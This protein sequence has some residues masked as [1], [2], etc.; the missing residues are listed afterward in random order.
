MSDAPTPDETR[1]FDRKFIGVSAAA[2][3]T[4]MLAGALAR[5]ASAAPAA[6][7]EEAT[8]AQLQALTTN[9]GLTAHSLVQSYLQRIDVIDRRGGLNSILELNP[10]AADIA[11]Q[12]D[13]ERK[14]GRVRGPLHG[15]PVTLKGNIDTGD[16]MQTTAGSLALAGAAATQDA[17]LRSSTSPRATRSVCRSGSASW[18]PPSASRS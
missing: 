16:K 8:I 17:G 3:A 11:K 1:R 14:A 6:Q 9:G 18:R 12:L 15:I 10:G 7:I 2:A 13:A 4:P 5:K